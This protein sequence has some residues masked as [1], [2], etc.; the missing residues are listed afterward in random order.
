MNLSLSTTSRLPAGL[1]N[2]AM[3]IADATSAARQDDFASILSR[4]SRGAGADKLT[5]EQK[6]RR[7]AEEFV[8]AALVEP[9][10]KNLRGSN[11]AWGPFKPGPGERQFRA[12][13]DAHLSRNL[14]RASNWPLVDGL[15]KRLSRQD[16]RVQPGSPADVQARESAR[17]NTDIKKGTQP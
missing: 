10:L 6:A 9:V 17:A 7:A 11:Q 8:A 13:A 14:T 4:A 15:A 16:E 5:P 12:L 3:S 1:S 2:P